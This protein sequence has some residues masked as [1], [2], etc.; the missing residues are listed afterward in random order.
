MLMCV[1]IPSLFSPSFSCSS[2]CHM[3]FIMLIIVIVFCVLLFHFLLCKETD[4]DPSAFLPQC[5]R[6]SHNRDLSF[7]TCH[8]LSEVISSFTAVQCTKNTA[9]QALG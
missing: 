2:S 7:L 6:K 9:A 3:F 4:F 5:N 1:F 8:S